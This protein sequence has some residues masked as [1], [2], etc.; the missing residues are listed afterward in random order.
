MYPNDDH[1]LILQQISGI[2]Q[3]SAVSYLAAGVWCIPME[4]ISSYSAV[5]YLAAGVWCIPVMVMSSYSA[6][7]YRQFCPQGSVVQLAVGHKDPPY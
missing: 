6:N 3:Y 1:F 4:I 2:S 7:L 5:P